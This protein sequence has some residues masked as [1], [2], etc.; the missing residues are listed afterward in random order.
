MIINI[1]PEAVAI[2]KRFFMALETLQM[3]RKIRGLRTFTEKYGL[4]Y[5]NFYTL[6]SEPEHRVMKA[7]YLTYIVRDF[8]VSADWLLLGV[9]DMF[10]ESKDTG[11]G[12]LG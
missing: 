12:V 1:A 7:E 11:D 5:W 9:G 8:G 2:T 10:K 3:Q 4:N 6:K